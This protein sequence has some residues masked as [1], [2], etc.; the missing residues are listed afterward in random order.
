[1]IVSEKNGLKYYQFERFL[2]H[3][4]KHG[5]FTRFGGVSPAPFDSLNM[6]ITLGDS[7]ENTKENV[8]RMLE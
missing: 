4:I 6:S 7:K 3:G 2:E 1:M 5:F 8:L